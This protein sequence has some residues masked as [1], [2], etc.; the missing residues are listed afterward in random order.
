ML[1]RALVVIVLLAVIVVSVRTAVFASPVRIDHS[2]HAIASSVPAAF[3]SA[4]A[5]IKGYTPLQRFLIGVGVGLIPGIVKEI[6]DDAFDTSDLLADFC[7]AVVGAGTVT[8]I[9]INF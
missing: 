2:M 7:G 8:L 1:C 4:Y 9:T 6:N 3:G 5:D